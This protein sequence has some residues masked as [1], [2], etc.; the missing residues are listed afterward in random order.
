VTDRLA[1]LRDRIERAGRDPRDVTVVA[2]TKGFGAEAVSEAITAGLVDIGE[3]YAD[4]VVTKSASVPGARWHFLGAVQRNKV[5]V[6][7]PLVS[8]WQT[9]DRLAAGEAIAQRAPGAAVF[10]QVNLVGD[11]RRPG[12]DEADAPALVDGLRGSGLEVRGLMGVA[13]REDPR[14]DFRRLA[15]LGRSVGLNELSMGMSSDLEAAVQEGSTMVRVGTA[16]FGA[17]PGVAQARR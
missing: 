6:L 16:L 7:A 12:C 11:P 2:V 13:G 14:A 1:E 9:V 15:A 5:K 3:N 17:R 10:V 4:E 8:C